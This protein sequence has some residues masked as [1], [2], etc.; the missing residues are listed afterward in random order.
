MSKKYLIGENELL[1]LLSRDLMFSAVKYEMHK[2]VRSANKMVKAIQEYL[3]QYAETLGF[4]YEEISYYDIARTRLD[5]YE[6][7]ISV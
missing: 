2:D 7:T 6:T 3:E 4:D 1:D 5:N